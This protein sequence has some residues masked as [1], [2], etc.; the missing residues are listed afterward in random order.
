M[1]Y[2][3]GGLLIFMLSLTNTCLAHPLKMSYTAARFFPEEERVEISFRIFQ[4]DFEVGLANRFNFRKDI[5]ATRNDHETITLISGYLDEMFDLEIDGI[6]YCMTY[7]GM[8]PEA[9]LGLVITYEITNVPMDH[10]E[11]VQVVNSILTDPFPQQ[12]NMFYIQI[13]EQLK[14]TRKFD[15]ET[16]SAAWKIDD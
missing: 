2:I 7:Q 14:T 8:Q 9:Q 13:P 10:L 1:I 5:L 3:K 16:H 11:T 6:E 15:L 4:D 12:V